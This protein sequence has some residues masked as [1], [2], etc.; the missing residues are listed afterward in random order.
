MASN[1]TG[2]RTPKE[3][4]MTVDAILSQCAMIRETGPG[5]FIARCPAHD[6]RSPSL[7][8]RE[9]NDGRVL[10]HCFAGCEV[11]SV[12]TAIGLTFSELYPEK[13]GSDI[14]H[15]PVRQRFDARQVLATL[16]HELLVASIIG[17]DFLEQKEIDEETWD[18]LGTAVHRINTARGKCAPARIG[19]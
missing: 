2:P 9:C 8:I 15:K 4:A 13:P 7:A 1:T 12:L 16:D 19:R 5:K 18:R 6:D 11:E 3:V 17:A 14:S 10:L